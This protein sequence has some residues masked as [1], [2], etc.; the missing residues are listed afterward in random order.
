MVLRFALVKRNANDTISLMEKRRS[1]N[2]QRVNL[3]TPM[4]K[5]QKPHNLVTGISISLRRFHFDHGNFSLNHGSSCLSQSV[6]IENISNVPCPH[7]KP[8]ENHASA[9]LW[10]STLENKEWIPLHWLENVLLMWSAVIWQSLFPNGSLIHST[11]FTNNENFRAAGE[12]VAASLALNGPACSFLEEASYK[13]LINPNLD[14][15]AFNC[16]FWQAF[17]NEAFKM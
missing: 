15:V 16:I 4:K 6:R 7:R 8:R 9:K 12:I 14:L 5:H 13:M 11:L 1:S 10:S 2:Q 3:G 17:S